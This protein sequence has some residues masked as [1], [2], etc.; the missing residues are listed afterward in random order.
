LFAQAFCIYY[1]VFAFIFYFKIK[2]KGTQNNDPIRVLD[3]LI[4]LLS[5]MSS[6]R[7]FLK[8]QS[9]LKNL[10]R[11]ESFSLIFISVKIRT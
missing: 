3:I 4:L 11:K 1:I 5:N 9:G 6:V 7:K 2:R 10:G 8:L